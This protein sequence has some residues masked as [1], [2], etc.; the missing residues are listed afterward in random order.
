MGSRKNR[1][2]VWGSADRSVGEIL[3]LKEGELKGGLAPLVETA[4]KTKIKRRLA[5]PGRDVGI[6]RAPLAHCGQPRARPIPLAE[7]LSEDYNSIVGDRACF[8]KARFNR[9]RA[10]RG[11]SLG[12]FFISRLSPL[13]LR[14]RTSTLPG[15]VPVTAPH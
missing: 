13:Q 15:A 3:S 12:A 6:A 7:G 10:P 4:R 11:L 5:A 2:V 8:S 1:T 9:F 14:H